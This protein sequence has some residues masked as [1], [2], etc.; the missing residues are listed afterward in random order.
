[1]VLLRIYAPDRLRLKTLPAID[2][3]ASVI[4]PPNLISATVSPFDKIIKFTTLFL[5][6][7]SRL[8]RKILKTTRQPLGRYT[9]NSLQIDAGS[10]N[11]TPPGVRVHPGVSFCICGAHTPEPPGRNAQSEAKPRDRMGSSTDRYSRSRGRFPG[12][13]GYSDP[14][15]LAAGLR[16][17]TIRK[18]VRNQNRRPVRRFAPFGPG[19]FSV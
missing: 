16:L 2:P 9:R 5:A 8:S 13:F 12:W 6:S 10:T 3:R 1:M 4:P 7:K 14:P 18:T 17:A 19:V 11:G 15:G